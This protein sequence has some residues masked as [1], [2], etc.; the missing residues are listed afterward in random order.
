[1]GI[2]LAMLTSDGRER[3]FALS[4]ARMVIGRDS[5]CDLRVPLPSVELRHCELTVD[6]ATIS[7]RDL[8]SICGTL[9]NGNRIQEQVSL[10]HGDRVTIGPVTFVVRVDIV[11]SEVAD[12][13][14]ITT[15]VRLKS[16]QTDAAAGGDDQPP[17]PVA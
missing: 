2:S 16:E 6:G 10:A 4:K 5:R 3:P 11:R 15:N 8:G 1:M 13:V 12:G 9:H 7:I 14:E 17:G